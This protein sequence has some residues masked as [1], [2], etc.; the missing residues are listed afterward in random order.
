MMGKNKK[1]VIGI[2]ITYIF[3]FAFLME[4]GFREIIGIWL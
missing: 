1:T 3:A 2:F 4:I